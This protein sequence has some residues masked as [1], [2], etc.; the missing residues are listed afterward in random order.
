MLAPVIHLSMHYLDPPAFRQKKTKHHT[1]KIQQRLQSLDDTTQIRV[2]VV[3]PPPPKE[4]EECVLGKL[5][6]H[7][8]LHGQ[9]NPSPPGPG[10]TRQQ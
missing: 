10:P 8:H 3:T 2:A 5:T 7:Q 1:R 4:F 6:I 9:R